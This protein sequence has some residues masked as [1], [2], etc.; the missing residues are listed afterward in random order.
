[1]KYRIKE[2]RKLRGM[3]QKQLAENVGTSQQT[4][5]RWETESRNIST[6]KKYRRH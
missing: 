3:T 1:M 5:Y 2:A 6:S 4:V